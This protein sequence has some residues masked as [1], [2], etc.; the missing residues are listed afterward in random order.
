MAHMPTPDYDK[1]LA[2]AIRAGES[3]DYVLAI[4][5]LLKIVSETDAA[6]QAYLYLGRA[7]HAV[8]DYDAAIQYLRYFVKMRPKVSAGHFFL[9]RTYLTQGLS[10]LAIRRLEASVTLDPTNIHPIMLL[11]LAHLKERQLEQ[12][13]QCF[14]RA[15][16]IDPNN[17]ALY[18]GYLNALLVQAIRHF[19]DGKI[20]AAGEMFTFLAERGSGGIV[21]HLY[22]ASIAKRYG[23]FETALK[24][25]DKALMAAPSDQMVRMQRADVLYRIGDRGS[26][27]REL[28]DAGVVVGGSPMDQAQVYR[29]NAVRAFQTGRYRKALAYAKRV[30]KNTGPDCEMHTLMGEALRQLDSLDRARNHF[31][32]AIEQDRRNVDPHLGLALTLWQLGEW[33]AMLPVLDRIETIQPGNEISGYY[34]ALCYCMLELPVEQTIPALLS[35]I[36]VSGSDVFLCTALAGQFR[37]AGR[38]TEA[39]DWFRKAISV[40]DDHVPAYRG[41]LEILMESNRS[42]D[43]IAALSQYLL[44]CPDDRPMRYELIHLLVEHERYAEAIE[45][46]RSYLSVAES[47]EELQRLMGFCLRRTGAYREAAGVYRQLLK[48][49]PDNEDYL[50]ALCFCLERSG[51]LPAALR[52]LARAFEYIDPSPALLLIHGVLLYKEGELEAALSKFREVTA[53]DPSDWRAYKNIGMVYRRNGLKDLA[54][55]FMSTAEEYRR[56]A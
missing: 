21:P 56:R 30:I 17:R 38:D 41:L 37:R 51:N 2:E 54:D 43:T 14:G 5:L 4:D 44:R 29:L 12:A 31:T 19:R 25:Y 6:P 13:V 20:R 55:K 28:R 35:Q 46:L 49:R 52:L 9:G 26:A 24:H 50:R 32:R 53:I 27:V 40:S 42:A 33:N 34:A 8:G 3:R 45:H 36:N 16:E 22:L 48:E 1:I 11:G 7:Y 10:R 18:G 15:V 39:E 23:D 47:T